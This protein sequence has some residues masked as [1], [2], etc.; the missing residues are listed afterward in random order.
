MKDREKTQDPVI[1]RKVS[2]KLSCLGVRAPCRVTVV[3]D[4][5]KVT[6]SGTIQYEGQRQVA[7]RGIKGVAGVESVVDKM[8]LIPRVPQWKTNP[9]PGGDS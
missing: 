3:S 9:G 7:L 6:L 2:E 4:K 8:Q 5:G 1:S